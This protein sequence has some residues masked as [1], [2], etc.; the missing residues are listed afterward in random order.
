MLAIV[1][2]SKSDMVQSP[3][4]DQSSTNAINACSLLASRDIEAIQG[5]PLK[6]T[7]Q[8]VSSQAGLKVSQCY[9]LLEK[10]VD[11][12]NI[13]I[14]QKAEGSSAR[15]PKR[16]WEEIFHG[17]KEKNKEEASKEEESKAAPP[18]K[19]DGLGDEA[20]WAPRRFGGALYA[21]KGNIYVTVS[22]G[23]ADE[24][25]AR[26]QKSKALAGILLKHL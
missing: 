8:S 16:A 7:K 17:E 3:A 5:A 23:G 11:S 25:A 15:D 6:D 20:F 21:L 13:T 19:I 2:C 14:T 22:V 26:L 18:E 4:A 24:K 10:A 9:F 12:I 1:G